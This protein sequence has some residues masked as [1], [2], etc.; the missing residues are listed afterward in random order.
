MQDVNF[1]T[2]RKACWLYH[3]SPVSRLRERSR[4]PTSLYFFLRLTL[5]SLTFG[6][7]MPTTITARAFLSV[8]SSPSDTCVFKTIFQSTHLYN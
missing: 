6:K 2:H 1:I 8:K 4:C 3:W 7:G 5:V